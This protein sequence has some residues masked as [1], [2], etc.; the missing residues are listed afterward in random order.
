LPSRIYALIVGLILAAGILYAALPRHGGKRPGAADH[1]FAADPALAAAFSGPPHARHATPDVADYSV[2]AH[3]RDSV[4]GAA[5]ET[6]RA[7]ASCRRQVPGAFTAGLQQFRDCTSI[8]LR[9]NIY[10]RKLEIPVLMQAV[11]N[12]RSGRCLQEA[13]AVGS[14]LAE[15]ADASQASFGLGEV[16]GSP[17]SAS[18]LRTLQAASREAIGQLVQLTGTIILATRGN[19]LRQVCR[20]RPYDPAEHGESA[21]ELQLRSDG[22]TA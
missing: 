22:P 5:V 12:L 9:H 19:E 4:R 15:L 20:P 6:S 16:A 18:D 14:Y 17:M 8:P 13:A 11:R 10:R 3:A 2:V 1:A 21:P 7:I